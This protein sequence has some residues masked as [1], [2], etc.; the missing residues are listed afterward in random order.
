MGFQKSSSFDF[1]GSVMGST[2]KRV[3]VDRLC[4]RF[5]HLEV[6][7][8]LCGGGKAPWKHMY[9]DLPYISPIWGK[10]V[11]TGSRASKVMI[12]GLSRRKG[13]IG[14]NKGAWLAKPAVAV[15]VIFSCLL[16]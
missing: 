10:R 13:T 1:H 8:L 11:P 5:L 14:S 7:H 3:A 2:C 12:A 9:L 6:V 4:L 16:G 15:V